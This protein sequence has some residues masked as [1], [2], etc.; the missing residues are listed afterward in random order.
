EVPRPGK[1]RPDHADGRALGI[2]AQDAGG[3]DPDREVGGAGNHR[4]QRVAAA[5]RAED[6]EDGSVLLEDAAALAE[7][8]RIDRPQPGR[9]RRPPGRSPAPARRSR[10]PPWDPRAEATTASADCAWSPS[11]PLA[12]RP[13][14]PDAASFSCSFI[15]R[16][17]GFG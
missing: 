11:R 7:P 5:R 1:I 3:A 6:I 12:Y 4:L 2:G 8:R 13:R 10:Q 16:A 17:A 9:P 15:S 14:V